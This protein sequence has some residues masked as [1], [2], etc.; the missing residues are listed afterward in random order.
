MRPEHEDGIDWEA[1]TWQGSRRRQLE[2]WAQMP[3]DEIFAAQEEMAEF[4]ADLAGDART[5]G[6]AD[7]ES[8]DD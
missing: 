3:L 6:H 8:K 5:E 4:A 7:Q 2:Y 1:T